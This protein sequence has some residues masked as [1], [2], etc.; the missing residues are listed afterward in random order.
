MKIMTI[1]THSLAEPDY[2]RKLRQLADVILKEKPDIL[3]MQE[4]NQSAQE[5]LLPQMEM[6]GY[7]SCTE[8]R[9][10]VRRDN[11]AARLA[12][13]LF[14]QK[15]PYYW[16]WL[17]MKLGYGIY[18]EGLAVFSRR[19][20]MKTDV[21]RISSCEAYEN[22]KTRW[23]LGILTDDPGAGWF[24]TVHMGWWSDEEE[25]FA[26]QWSR[27]EEHLAGKKNSES[28]V[29]L[30]GDFNSQDDIRDQGY[31]LVCK[32]G[33]LD[34]WK[35]A[36][37][38]DSGITVEKEIDGW[39]DQTPSCGGETGQKAGMRIDYIWCSREVPVERSRVICN[40]KWYP[41]V[42][43]HYGVMVQTGGSVK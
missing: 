23:M 1:N 33:W 25:P 10:S 38:K 39:R 28:P 43:D 24:Y 26:D 22:W 18:D 14:L 19:P 4:V 13:I 31:D 7:V 29:W 6:P 20:V 30:M 12:Q 9:V 35:L 17:P 15:T 3:A 34:T 5:K 2:E 40:G 37:G 41:V 36:A 8:K 32:S 16:T 27:L 11:H 42:S 21:F